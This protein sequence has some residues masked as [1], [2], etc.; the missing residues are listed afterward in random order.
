M[1]DVE[2]PAEAIDRHAPFPEFP[3]EHV[4]S[5]AVRGDVARDH[6]VLRALAAELLPEP[7]QVTRIHVDVENGVDAMVV[8]RFRDVIPTVRPR[9]VD[10]DPLS[11]WILLAAH[12]YDD[13]RE[14]FLEFGE[15]VEH[16]DRV[17]HPRILRKSFPQ[18]R[19]H[20]LPTDFVTGVVD[21]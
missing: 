18:R 16:A 2:N 9:A 8:R 19:F 10:H 7:P 6:E 13:F 21:R 11:E 20:H 3:D 4:D 14:R 1:S 17:P 15:P 12:P 5:D